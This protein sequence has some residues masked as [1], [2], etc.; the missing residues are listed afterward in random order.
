MGG[1]GG[2][3]AG[4]GSHIPEQTISEAK[5]VAAKKLMLGKTC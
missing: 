2:E 4:V 5:T 1:E 3:E